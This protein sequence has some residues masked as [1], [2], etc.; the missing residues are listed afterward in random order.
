MNFSQKWQLSPSGKMLANVPSP[1]SGGLI[2]KE[3]ERAR[4][5]EREE[6]REREGEREKERE[7][8]RERETKRERDETKQLMSRF[9][10]LVV[11]KC[12]G[13]HLS[14]LKRAGAEDRL[15]RS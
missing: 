13:I 9:M 4:Q 14:R 7:N 3:K 15:W 12:T 6:E 8:E 1:K 2:E 10:C 5:R 11:L